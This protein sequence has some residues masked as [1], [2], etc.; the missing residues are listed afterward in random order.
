MS[1]EM[2]SYT[3]TVDIYVHLLNEGTDVVRPTKAIPLG[4]MRY[5]IL[6]TSDY[7]PDLEEWEFPPGSIVECRIENREGKQVLV[8]WR[9]VA[10]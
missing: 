4:R 9:K 2:V 10:E 5:K 6:P 8:A 3:D 7:S 1:G